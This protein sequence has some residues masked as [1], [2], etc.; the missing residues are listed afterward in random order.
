MNMGEAPNVWLY[1]RTH[2]GD[3][4]GCGIFGIHE[5]MA[6]A[7]KECIGKHAVIG[8]GGKT[9][10]AGGG[11]RVNWVGIGPH[12]CQDASPAGNIMVR[13]D[14]FCL[15]DGEAGLH[16][17]TEAPTLCKYMFEEGRIPRKGQSSGVDAEYAEAI[18]R[19]IQHILQ[20]FQSSPPSRDRCECATPPSAQ[21]KS[22]GCK[23]K[24]PPKP[25]KS[26]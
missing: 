16:M 21:H 17:A 9:H 18:N 8:I 13:F 22:C 5:C 4:C 19:E 2:V 1:R 23:P 7:R 12:Q 10:D 20:K 11:M 26:C 14:H 25:G 6:S 15:I 3:P 24:P